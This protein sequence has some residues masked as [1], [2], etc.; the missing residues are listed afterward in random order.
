MVA[1]SKTIV[2]LCGC[3][4]I[5]SDHLNW[6][7]V[8]ALLA[9]HPLKPEFLVD[10]LACGA[11]NLEHLAELLRQKQPEH[12][13]VAACS[14]R[15]HE[16]TF[17]KLLADTGI[18]PWQLQM[19]N[20]REQV[21][22]VTADPQQATHK[23]AR[24]I[25][26][27]LNRIRHHKPLYARHQKVC[28]EVVVIG[29]GPAGMQAALTLAR[30]GRKVTLIEKEPFIG[31]LPVRFEE[32]FPNLECGPCLLEPL[33]GDLLHGAESDL[34]QLL[35][36]SEVTAVSGSFGNW[37]L[38]VRQNPRYIN[39][40]L[41]IGCMICAELCP[42]KRHNHWNQAGEIS[43]IDSPFA[44]A[45]PNLPHI[46]PSACLQL[47][48]KQCDICLENCPVPDAISFTDKM[49]E[50][51]IHAGAIIIASG[52]VELQE[53][54]PGFANGTEIHTAYSFERL[55]AMN[56]PTGGE[57]LKK[58]GQPPA[59]LAIIHC[60][61]SLDE[62]EIV[63]CSGICCRSGM[64]Y[65]HLAA[66]KQP[67]LTVTRLVREQ[68]VPGVE[69]AALFH[70]DHS[71]LVRYQGLSDLVL[72]NADGEQSVF[73]RST[74]EQIAAEMILLLRPIVPG[75][76]TAAVAD[77]LELDCDGAGFLSSLHSLADSCSS[78]LKGIY[79]AGSCR[80]A[81]DL[82]NAFAS[83]VA[84]AGHVLSALVEGRQLVVDPQVA[85]VNAD[86]CA[87]CKTC[88]QL[89]P[90]KAISWNE[91]DKV[92]FVTDILCRGCGVCVAACPSGAISGQG[93][94][95]EMLRAELKGVL[96]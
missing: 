92:A 89:C 9:R 30:A 96:S 59:S 83:G 71:R 85:V 18:N 55:L 24:M 47:Q 57:L 40:D 69:A 11:E 79:L 86:L 50:F 31:G 1:P 54:L 52:A 66:G 91:Q 16:T 41:C 12:L 93:F 28:A 78:T 80:G 42:A 68:V 22:W 75:D 21:V 64:K 27:A 45:L 82:R 13:V 90:Y 20:I 56:G 77:I 17:R 4:G 94:T 49:S 35:T 39:P 88:L 8:Q 73:C 70:G 15:E 67:G 95:R 84:S 43:A 33:M 48:G 63:Y 32:L 38:T 14:P 19:V 58:N 87:G 46:E 72:Q 34:V 7:K 25:F 6:E 3:S 5:I 10:E 23:A 37:N 74:G 36:L 81:D 62:E 76:G 26:A 65:S 53:L 60:A 44:G 29:A 51:Q 61:G 2:I